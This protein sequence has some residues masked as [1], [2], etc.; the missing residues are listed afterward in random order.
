MDKL[1]KSISGK[2]TVLVGPPLVGE[3]EFIY[4]YILS[5]LKGGMPVVIISTDA[6]PDGFKKRYIKGKMLLEKFEDEGLLKYIDCYSKNAGEKVVDTSSIK[7]VSG[8][9]ALNEISI[10]LNDVQKSFLGK[11]E[12]HTVIFN[13]LSTL[14]MYSNSN[15]VARFIQVFIS[16]VKRADGDIIFTLEQGMHDEKT[17]VTLE[18]LMDDILEMKKEGTKIM[19]KARGI[20]GYEDWTEIFV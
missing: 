16:K 17:I 15:A 19:I 1:F 3:K 14:L 13:S 7:R 8:P 9:L 2:A 20:E 12:G 18:H 4:N 5:K 10:A 6:S 11:F